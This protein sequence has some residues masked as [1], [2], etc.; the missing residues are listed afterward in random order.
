MVGAIRQAAV[1]C[2]RVDRSID[3][4][5]PAFLNRPTPILSLALRR[6]ARS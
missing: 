5:N 4:G 6:P 1:I 2:Q 3:R